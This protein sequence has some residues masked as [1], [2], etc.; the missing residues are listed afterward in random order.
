M[1]IIKKATTSLVGMALFAQ[2]AFAQDNPGFWDPNAPVPDAPSKMGLG[3][4]IT[5][6]IN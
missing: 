3:Q 4:G 1:N 6:I 5:G 2:N